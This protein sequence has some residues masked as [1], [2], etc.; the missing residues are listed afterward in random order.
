MSIIINLDTVKENVLKS[1]MEILQQQLKYAH[2]G[3]FQS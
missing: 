1:T 3:P 2:M